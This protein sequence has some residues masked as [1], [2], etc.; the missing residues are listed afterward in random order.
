MQTPTK[1]F[2]VSGVITNAWQWKLNR[3]AQV[4]SVA[5][6]PDSVGLAANYSVAWGC[7]ALTLSIRAVK[8]NFLVPRPAPPAKFFNSRGGML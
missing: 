3:A 2:T 4:A 5:V 7:F 8:K 6:A 1:S